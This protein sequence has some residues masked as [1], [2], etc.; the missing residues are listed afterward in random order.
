MSDDDL[1]FE[2][3]ISLDDDIESEK[4]VGKVSLN[5]GG[6]QR[7]EDKLEELRLQRLEQDYDF[8]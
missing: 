5:I 1:G 8:L 3:E 6:R 2:E 4:V 7:V